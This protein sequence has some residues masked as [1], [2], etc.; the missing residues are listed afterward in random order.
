[1]EQRASRGLLCQ[2]LEVMVVLSFLKGPLEL[3]G[4]CTS[5]CKHKAECREGKEIQGAP[6]TDLRK[7]R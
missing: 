7:Q 2:I 6:V 3:S 1:M 5:S 4:P